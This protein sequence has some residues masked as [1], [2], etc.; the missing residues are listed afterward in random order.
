MDAVRGVTTR[1]G[2]TFTAPKNISTPISFLIHQSETLK[3]NNRQF[4]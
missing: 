3:R 2:N 1:D 4:L